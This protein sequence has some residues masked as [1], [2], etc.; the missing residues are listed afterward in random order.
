VLIHQ[1]AYYKI[2][3]CYFL[4]SVYN[5]NLSIHRY[6]PLKEI[7]KRIHSSPPFALRDYAWSGYFVPPNVTYYHFQTPNTFTR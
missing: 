7:I 5:T 6:V 3:H 1:Q 4:R 2:P